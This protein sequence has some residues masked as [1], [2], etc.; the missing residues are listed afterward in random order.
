MNFEPQKFFIGL[1]D[2]FSI[3]MP[4]AVLTWAARQYAVATRNDWFAQPLDG[5]E[6]WMVFFF[7]SYLLGHVVFLIGA[8]ADNWLYDPLRRRT[9]WGQVGN[10]GDGKRLA[11]GW[12]R[13]L[14]TRRWLFGPNADGALLQVQRLKARE[15]GAEAASA[16]NV[17]QWSKAR[18]SK[19]HPEGLAVVQ[20]FEADSKFFRSFM[21]VLL[22]F[23][24]VLLVTGPR[25]E[26]VVYLVLVLLAALRYTDQRFK[27]TQQAY[28]FGI[29]LEGLPGPQTRPAPVHPAAGPAP[30]KPTHGGGVVFKD[31]GRSIHY[32]LVQS[33]NRFE[34][35]LPKGHI[36]PGEKTRETAVRE[37]LEE[38]G[39]WA[40]VCEWLQD[41]QLGT[42]PSAAT[43]R[44]YL[45]EF[46]D[47]ATRG[48]WPAENR[49]SD[50]LTLTDALLRV[51]HG[52]SRLLIE[53]A[54]RLRAR[55]AAKEK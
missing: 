20:R 9:M 24:V 7:A 35:V 27:A 34:W 21:I 12:Y 47:D 1:M 45:M 28:W 23:A 26:G 3:L 5:A 40:R 36:E 55:L 22:P 6:A 48:R 15:L 16:I 33:S 10:L 13:W 17:F 19:L 32:L 46:Q 49:Q 30:G 25:A 52:E 39:Q 29:T 2:F 8:T 11:W 42:G 14:V 4:G 44:F 53:N 41:I 43:V 31:D 54:D 51:T 50:W 18:L 37:V 38:T